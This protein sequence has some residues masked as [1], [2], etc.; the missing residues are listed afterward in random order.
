MTAHAN[1]KHI[2]HLRLFEP[3]KVIE[4]IADGRDLPELDV[5]LK[6][7]LLLGPAGRCLLCEVP[8]QIPGVMGWTDVDGGKAAFTVCMN[9]TD[10]LGPETEQAICA[11]IGFRPMAHAGSS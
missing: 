4:A 11:K 1:L 10:E 3:R 6:V 7:M 9:C 5:Q 8:A 2:S